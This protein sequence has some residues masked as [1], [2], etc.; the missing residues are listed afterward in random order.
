MARWVTELALV[1]LPDPPSGKPLLAD[2]PR[3]TVFFGLDSLSKSRDETVRRLSFPSALKSPL[4]FGTFESSAFPSG[5]V[6]LNFAF[7]AAV[8]VNNLSGTLNV[9]SRGELVVNV[10]LFADSGSVS[11]Q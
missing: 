6:R 8:G 10:E 4:S 9:L 3:E 2:E 1:N 5:V 7:D 11:S